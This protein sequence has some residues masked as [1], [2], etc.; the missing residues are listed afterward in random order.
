MIGILI[1]ISI[2]AVGSPI[3]LKI[4]AIAV[5]INKYNS[6]IYKKKKKHDKIVAALDKSGCKKST[7]EPFTK[8]KQEKAQNFKETWDSP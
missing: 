1:E 7:C 2:S 5:R 6:V 3:G 4:C 8:K